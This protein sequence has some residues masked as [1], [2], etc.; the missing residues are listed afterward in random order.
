MLKHFSTKGIKHLGIEPS[1]NVALEANKI[2]INTISV[3]FTENLA[4]SIVREQGHADIFM[5]ANVMCHI[6]NICD[7]VRGIK[8]LLKNNGVAIFEDPYLGDIVQ[9]VSYDQIY[10]EHVFLFSA[11]SVKY[12]FNMHGMD[13]ID[14]I[15]QKTHGGSMRYVLANRG[16]YPKKPSVDLLIQEEA[17]L[18]LDKTATYIELASK[19]KK[20]KEDLLKILLRLKG[21]GKSLA[22]YGATSK[23]TTI[24][25]YCGINSSILSFI[26]D[27]TPIKQ[28]R[29]TPGTHIPVVPYQHFINNPPD[30][31]VLF[32]WNHSEEIFEKERLYAEGGGRWILHVP[33]VRIL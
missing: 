10:D 18:G 19:I 33:E 16:V 3:F 2:G 13:L 26:C 21:E 28:G 32:A 23:S 30:Y 9:K 22:G 20:S 15:P 6:P 25:N 17:R 1:K 12:L 4:E 7:V 11:L 24:L 5:A 27:T 29:L 8:K 31:T 14:V